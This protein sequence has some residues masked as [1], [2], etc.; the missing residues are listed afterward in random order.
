VVTFA[1][2]SPRAGLPY[3]GP[4]G[5]GASATLLNMVELPENSIPRTWLKNSLRH[6]HH[7]PPGRR[8]VARSGPLA[9]G[10][11]E[12]F[13]RQVLRPLDAA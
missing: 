2:W 8:R 12:L 11:I 6:C 10:A 13:V 9:A 4:F 1:G 7:R 5:T 3:D